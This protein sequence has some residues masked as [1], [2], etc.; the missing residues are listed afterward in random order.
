MLKACKQDELEENLDAVCEFYEDDFEREIHCSQLQ[1]FGVHFREVEGSAANVSIF[2]VKR[3]FVS[4]SHGQASQVRHLLQLILVMPAMNATSERSFSALHRLK[5]YLDN[6]ETR[7]T[8]SL[9]GD[10][11][12]QRKDRWSRFKGHVERVCW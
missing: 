2:D 8:Q 10:A 3:Y 12:E 11:R 1:T 5:N 4:L 6:N 9:N 7:E